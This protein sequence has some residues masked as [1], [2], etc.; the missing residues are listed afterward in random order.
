MKLKDNKLDCGVRKITRSPEVPKHEILGALNFKAQYWS[1]K[2]Q[3]FAVD[4][5]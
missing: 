2:K 1:M 4:K 5:S 3:V